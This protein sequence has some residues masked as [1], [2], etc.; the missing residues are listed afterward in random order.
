VLFDGYWLSDGPVS[1]AMVQR[2][3]IETWSTTF[4]QDEIYVTVRDGFKPIVG[5][6]PNYLNVTHALH[7]L[8][9]F[10]EVP[11]LARKVNADVVLTHNFSSP[12][13]RAKSYVFIHDFIF[14]DQP[15][16]FT[17]KEQLYF[18]L[19]PLSSV[20]ARK[21]FT[22]SSTEAKRIERF[23]KRDV[24]STLLGIDPA[25]RE[26]IPISPNLL[27]KPKGFM[28]TIGRL[29]ERKNLVLTIESALNSD[30]VTTEE[31]LVVVGEKSGKFSG[32]THRVMEAL[33]SGRV[34]FLGSLRTEEIAWLY[35]NCSNFLFFSL[36][37]GYGLPAIEALYFGSPTKV[38]DIPV[39][40]ELVGLYGIFAN[41]RDSL[42]IVQ[43]I[44]SKSVTPSGGITPP[45]WQ[46][47]VA[48]IRSE[49]EK[50]L[51]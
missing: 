30:L 15:K 4:P 48:K 46:E 51:T 43:A 21:I 1:N 31:P 41:P 12:T 18:W 22:S 9:T 32:L 39:F 50:N 16:W 35:I 3:I 45:S 6:Q 17:K 29:T 11:R 10:F 49:I 23:L 42:E 26:A 47:V 37:E 13:K 27:L 24:F 14:M 36:D 20:F 25:L 34:I 7:A 44:N 38:S 33:E 28:L 2:Q 8:S 40:R 19:M 5:I